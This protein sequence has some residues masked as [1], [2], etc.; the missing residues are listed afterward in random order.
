MADDFLHTPSMSHATSKYLKIMAVNYSFIETSLEMPKQFYVTLH[1]TPPKDLRIGALVRLH[2]S[3]ISSQYLHHELNGAMFK[4]SGLSGMR[5][6][7]EPDIKL[8]SSL[9]GPLFAH[10]S[11]Y[12]YYYDSPFGWGIETTFPSV[13]SQ[14]NKVNV[15]YG[16]GIPIGFLEYTPIEKIDW[17]NLF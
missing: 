10:E 8:S 13:P 17:W 15:K 9:Y 14:P 16:F 1:H 11:N 5:V 4:V 2:I 12:R 6:I 3:P 7:L